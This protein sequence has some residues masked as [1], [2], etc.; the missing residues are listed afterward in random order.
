MYI[1]HYICDLG[2]WR[3]DH[4]HFKG[5]LSHYKVDFSLKQMVSATEKI[6]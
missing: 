1:I 5:Y 6:I 3:S 4:S 2:H